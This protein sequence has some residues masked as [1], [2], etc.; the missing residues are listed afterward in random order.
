MQHKVSNQIQFCRDIA[1]LYTSYYIRFNVG[2]LMQVTK[3]ILYA[4]IV[5]HLK[6]NPGTSN[7]ACVSHNS[8]TEAAPISTAV[9]MAG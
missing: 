6:K 8:V 1:D 4:P 3:Y 2:Q 7:R 5:N 9:P